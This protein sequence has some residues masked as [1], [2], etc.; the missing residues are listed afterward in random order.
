MKVISVESDIVEKNGHYDCDH[1]HLQE[2]NYVT[3]PNYHLKRPD[4]L[5]SGVRAIALAGALESGVYSTLINDVPFLVLDLIG[6]GD[7]YKI[8]YGHL[9]ALYASLR[10]FPGFSKQRK[11]VLSN[12]QQ[13]FSTT[14]GVAHSHLDMIRWQMSLAIPMHSN[15]CDKYSLLSK[16]RQCLC[17]VFQ[18]SAAVFV[19][20]PLH[21]PNK[22]ANVADIIRVSQLWD[23][24]FAVLNQI[25]EKIKS[26]TS[27]ESLSNFDITVREWDRRHE[28]LVPQNLWEQSSFPKVLRLPSVDFDQTALELYDTTR[29]LNSISLS[30]QCGT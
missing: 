18:W 19:T 22:L 25:A 27:R 11:D 14:I 20:L 4:A 21:N 5:L 1:D 13:I 9:K 29:V 23:D 2:D 8:Y 16:I 12:I 17:L 10:E 24:L 26:F 3:T 30:C 7:R 15:S 28:I 6:L